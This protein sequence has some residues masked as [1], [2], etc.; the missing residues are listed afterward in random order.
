MVLEEATPE[1]RTRLLGVLPAPVRLLVRTVF[2]RR[3]R[4]YVRRVRG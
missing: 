1:E 4:R 3:Y 2:A